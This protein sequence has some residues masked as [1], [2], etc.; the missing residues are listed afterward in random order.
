MVDVD[1]AAIIESIA[2]GHSLTVEEVQRLAFYALRVTDENYEIVD[3]RDSFL[4]WARR[5]ARELADERDVYRAE[6]VHWQNLAS[7]LAG[8]L[9]H[10]NAELEKWAVRYFHARYSQV[11]I[12]GLPGSIQQHLADEA[13]GKVVVRHVGYVDPFA[14]HPEHL[15]SPDDEPDIGWR[16]VYLVDEEAS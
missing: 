12:S 7:N 15:R 13:M 9:A 2:A 4:R 3:A 1:P 10:A 5:W 8:H 16:P 14:N 6:A 11:D